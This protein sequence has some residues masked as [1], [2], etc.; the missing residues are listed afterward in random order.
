MDTCLVNEVER[1][2]RQ[3]LS[4]EEIAAGMGVDEEWVREVVA[5]LEEEAL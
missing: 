3:G 1:L 5:L 2:W 4:P